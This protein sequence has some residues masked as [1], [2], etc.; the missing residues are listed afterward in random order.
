MKDEEKMSCGHENRQGAGANNT[1]IKT[2]D[3]D[4]ISIVF[5]EYQI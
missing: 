2:I 5:S 1:W 3:N 4:K